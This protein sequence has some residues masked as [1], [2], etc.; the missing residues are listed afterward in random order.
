MAN[1][2]HYRCRSCGHSFSRTYGVD[3]NGQAELCCSRCGRLRRVDFSLGWIP[4]SDCDCGG[5]FD[6]AALGCCPQCG[7]ML[8][9]GDADGESP[10]G[11]P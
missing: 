5:S 11:T 4:I 8:E 3:I 2:L 6:P 1:T 10:A 7:K 9:K